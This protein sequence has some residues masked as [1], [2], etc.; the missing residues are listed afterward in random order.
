MHK[1]ILVTDVCRERMYL[2]HFV[3]CIGYSVAILFI[4]KKKR[5][6]NGF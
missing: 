2:L 5:T 3:S 1:H 6:L 4:Q